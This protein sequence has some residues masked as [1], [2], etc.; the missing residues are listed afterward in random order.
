MKSKDQ[1]LLEEA[2]EETKTISANI[3]TRFTLGHVDPREEQAVFEFLR[4]KCGL[5]FDTQRKKL[6]NGGGYHVTYQYRGPFTRGEE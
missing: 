5:D 1:Q 2:Y 6:G 4:F 3:P